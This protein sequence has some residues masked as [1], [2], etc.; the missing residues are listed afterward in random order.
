MSFFHQ[1]DQYDLQV[2]EEVLVGSYSRQIWD[3][4][5]GHTGG[6]L[7]LAKK[8]YRSIR[9]VQLRRECLDA[10]EDRSE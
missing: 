7:I 9:S 2:A 3:M 6:N 10:S 1:S 5:I 4:V 8:M